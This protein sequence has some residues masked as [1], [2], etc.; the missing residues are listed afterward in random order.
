MQTSANTGSQ[1]IAA[2]AKSHTHYILSLHQFAGC[3]SIRP[4]VSRF[5]GSSVPADCQRFLSAPDLW[6]MFHR[7]ENFPV[8]P[9][10]A[11]ASVPF[12]LRAAACIAARLCSRVAVKL[13]QNVSSQST[14]PDGASLE[15]RNAAQVTPFQ[16]ADASHG[17]SGLRPQSPTLTRRF[18]AAVGSEKEKKI[19]T[20]G[21]MMPRRIPAHARQPVPR[22]V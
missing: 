7:A 10:P 4:E 16:H 14:I 8:N 20:E 19:D 15:S 5:P 1:N 17:K 22:T 12:A 11:A 21:G 6:S 13:Q 3:V 18:Q 9:A 2:E